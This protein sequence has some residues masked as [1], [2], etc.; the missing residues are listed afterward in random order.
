MGWL[1]LRPHWE[2]AQVAI[3]MVQ[4]YARKQADVLRAATNEHTFNIAA[5]RNHGRIGTVTSWRYHFCMDNQASTL[6]RWDPLVREH[7]R[8]V[9]RTN[10]RSLLGEI[11]VAIDEHLVREAAI[12]EFT[13][14]GTEETKV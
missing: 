3:G 8:Q 9:A 4:G 13:R 1:A 14:T 7:L 12:G 5:R 6:L 10:R 2:V 11:R